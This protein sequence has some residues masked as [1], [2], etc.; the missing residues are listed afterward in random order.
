VAAEGLTNA[1]KYANA[2]E[3]N[4]CAEIKIE[5]LRLSIED[6]GIGGADPRKGS[7]LVGLKDRVE[8]L[9]GHTNV[10]SAPEA[11]HLC[12]S[13]SPSRAMGDCPKD[14]GGQPIQVRQVQ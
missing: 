4:V 3:V 2:S 7:G 10:V 6:D 12:T 13:P 14:D 8:A 11:G 5:S 9:G 1:A